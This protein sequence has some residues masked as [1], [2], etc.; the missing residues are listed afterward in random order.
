MFEKNRKTLKCCD[1]K[2]FRIY[3]PKK[4]GWKIAKKK[5]RCYSKL[6]KIPIIVGNAREG[7]AKKR[8]V[9]TNTRALACIAVGNM[10]TMSNCARAH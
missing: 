9:D 5:T 2:Y 3:Y 10:M 1:K 4:L 7:E 6:Y 8:N